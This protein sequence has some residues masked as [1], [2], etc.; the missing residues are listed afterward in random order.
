MKLHRSQMTSAERARAKQ[1][2]DHGTPTLDNRVSYFHQMRDDKCP[3][4]EEVKSS[5]QW[6]SAETNDGT[7]HRWGPDLLS[8]LAK[9]PP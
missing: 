2:R 1:E 4:S 8:V 5:V 3:T 6:G 7:F 9:L